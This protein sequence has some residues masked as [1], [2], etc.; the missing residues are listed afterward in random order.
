[1][2]SL[3]A[4]RRLA[5]MPVMRRTMRDKLPLMTQKRLSS[6]K[7]IGYR[8][9]GYSP[10][11]RINYHASEVVLGVIYWWVLWNFYTD[12]RHLVGEF[13]WP[14]QSGWSDEHLGIPPDDED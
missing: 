7:Y 9:H 14:E 1:M 3:I 11:G 5:L 2:L 12:W 6:D 13:I 8:E 4:A 10:K